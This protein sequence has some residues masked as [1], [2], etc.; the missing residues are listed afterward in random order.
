MPDSIDIGGVTLRMISF[1][2][3]EN[4]YRGDVA[5][6]FSN[7]LL[8]GRDAPR[9]SWEGTTD[10]ITPAEEAA[11]RAVVDAGNTVCTG[12]VLNDEEV[13]CCVTIGNAPL[14]P[15]VQSGPPDYTAINVSL[16]LVL[17]EA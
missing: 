8:D 2:R 4:V 17:Q 9:R 1:Q 7:R 10:W 3:R 15:N 12:L 11:L 13:L 14:G 5:A 6:S 16:A